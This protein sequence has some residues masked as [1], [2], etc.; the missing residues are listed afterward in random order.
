MSNYTFRCQCGYTGSVY[1]LRQGIEECSIVRE[2]D[3]EGY[4]MD[5]ETVYVSYDNCRSVYVC[6]GC[7]ARYDI[8]MARQFIEVR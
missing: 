3:S 2:V 4:S 5:D 6:P 8:G 1:I 7:D